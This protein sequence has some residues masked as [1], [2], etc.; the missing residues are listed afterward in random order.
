MGRHHGP[1]RAVSRDARPPRRI[2]GI[3]RL[4]GAVAV[5]GLSALSL[6]GCASHPTTSP[7]VRPAVSRPSSPAP[8]ASAAA[9]PAASPTPCPSESGWTGQNLSMAAPDPAAWLT[10][11]EMPDAA[12]YQWTA[13]GSPIA[14]PFAQDVSYGFYNV[15]VNDYLAWQ[16]EDYQ[17]S[18]SGYASQDIFLYAS[19]AQAHCQ[20]LSA[21]AGAAGNQAA[22]RSLQAQFDIPASAVTT[23]PASGEDDSVW[24]ESWTTP[25]SYFTSSGSWTNVDYIVQ[26]GT[27]VTFVSYGVAGLNQGIPD[28]AA[29]QA[30]L[31]EIIL[32]LSVYA[33]GS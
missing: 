12:V 5:V 24:A 10:A 9:A 16:I 27:A 21:V 4:S 8:V 14:Q 2:T 17:G 7:P 15:A 3:S 29:A 26:V 20:Y 32:H 18:M 6:A 11:A 1:H 33:T 30:T 28:A 22:S 23:E 25:N 13:R 31:S 19:E